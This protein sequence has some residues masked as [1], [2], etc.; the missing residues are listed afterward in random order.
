MANQDGSN[1]NINDYKPTCPVIFFERGN[2][3][4][5]QKQIV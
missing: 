1:D 2:N 5:G 4:D 3:A